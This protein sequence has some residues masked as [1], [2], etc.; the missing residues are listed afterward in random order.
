MKSH[1]QESSSIQEIRNFFNS[2]NE[3]DSN[4]HFTKKKIFTQ[5]L[6]DSLTDC[7]MLAVGEMLADKKVTSQ[8]EVLSAVLMSEY[9]IDKV[10]LTNHADLQDLVKD[11]SELEDSTWFQGRGKLALYNHLHSKLKRE[12]KYFNKNPRKNHFRN[13]RW[14]DFCSD[15]VILAALGHVVHDKSMNFLHPQSYDQLI[16]A[17]EEVWM[18]GT[19]GK[20]ASLIHGI[21][22]I[23]KI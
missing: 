9:E 14:L 18:S 10:I 16:E 22:T 4:M 11:L 8:D 23:I 6:K 19:G 21:D 13:Q 3:S 2:D 15:C 20:R 12:N 7:S 1:D 17:D 5:C